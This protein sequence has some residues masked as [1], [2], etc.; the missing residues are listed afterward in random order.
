MKR[1]NNFNFFVECSTG[2]CELSKSKQKDKDGLPDELLIYGVA[3][4]NHK[5]SDGETLEP[6]G[7]ELSRFLKSGFLN[8]EHKSKED[9]AYIVGEPK[10]AFIKNNELHIVGKLYKG[11]DKARNIY[12]TIKLLEEEGSDRKIG[13]SIEGKALQR[14]PSNNKRIT[15]ALIT[16]CAITQSAKNQNTW[17]S[18][19]K[20]EQETDYVPN[21]EANGG[22]VYLLDVTKPDGTR[23]RVDKDFHI[24]VDKAMSTQS[25]APLMPE[26]LGGKKQKK[27]VK[28]LAETFIKNLNIIN[29]GI[30][31]GFISDKGVKMVKNKV[32]SFF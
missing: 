6:S 25:G 19:V 17:A 4:T 32:K 10:D 20:G 15:K 22:Q 9:L 13:Y 30:K 12:K 29:E 7:F 1:D 27:K 23:I 11:S 21:T 28:D 26:S 5:D 14:D 16:N 2:K 3:S 8:L 31:K 24:K 18:I